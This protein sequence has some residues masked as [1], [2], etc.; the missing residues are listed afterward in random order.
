MT[1]KDVK[2]FYKTGYRFHKETGMSQNSF[3]NWINAGFIPLDSQM[4]LEAISK[5][6]L[7]VDFD[8]VKENLRGKYE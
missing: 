3:H 8:A 6:E 2:K 4:R 7:K 5:G 1:P